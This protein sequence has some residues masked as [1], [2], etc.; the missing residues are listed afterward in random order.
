MGLSTRAEGKPHAFAP[1]KDTEG[2]IAYAP[3]HLKKIMGALT[4][5]AHTQKLEQYKN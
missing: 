2:S 5:E 4:L 3:N 1:H